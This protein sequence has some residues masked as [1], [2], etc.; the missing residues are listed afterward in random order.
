MTQSRINA[1]TAS[2]EKIAM[3]TC[4]D[5]SF[6]TLM[7]QADVDVLLVGD[8]LGMVL[9]GSNDTLDVSMQDMEYHTRCVANGADHTPIIADMPYG[10][11]QDP[12]HALPNA[13]RLMAAGAH[14]VKL[15]GAKFDVVEC[16][17]A[18]GIPVCGHL[19]FTPQSV[20]ELGGY[21]VQGRDEASASQMLKDALALQQAGA[22]M[23]VL[24]MVPAELAKTLTE[25]LSI[26]T[27]G[28]GA[29]PH[30]DGQVLVVQDMLGIYPGKTPRFARNF[31]DGADSVQSALRHYVQAVKDGS[32]PT[33]TH[34]F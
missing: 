9:Q 19:G 5:A 6:A 28:I 17:V 13:H 27:I 8:S 31:L 4:Y 14:M 24:E 32:F 11:D 12:L 25:A 3:L 10:S 22:S 18:N 16:L 30:C 7:E 33:A 1:L 21:K 29:G 26:P 34:S 23:L 15:E 20:H 2:G